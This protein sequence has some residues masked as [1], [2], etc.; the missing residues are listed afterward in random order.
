MLRVLAI[1]TMVSLG[2]LHSIWYE[3]R[4]AD[5]KKEWETSPTWK[6]VTAV[7]IAFVF[8]AFIYQNARLGADKKI[9]DDLINA[10][11]IS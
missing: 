1:I 5:E 9:H 8:S 10:K 4:H 11:A 6:L 2:T 7:F 3:F